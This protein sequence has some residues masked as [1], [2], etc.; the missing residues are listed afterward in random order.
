[1]PHTAP[2]IRLE[3]GMQPDFLEEIN[4]IPGGEHVKDCIQ[5]G[6]CSGSCPAA[7]NMRHTPRQI[8]AMIRAGMR[9]E[10]LTSN[11]M[12]MCA[13]CYLCQSRCP[14]NIKITDIMYALKRVALAEGKAQPKAS[15]MAQVFVDNINAYGRNDERM[16]IFNYYLK[17]NPGKFLSYAP[18]GLS[19]VNKGLLSLGAPER[20]KNIDQIRKIVA[21]VNKEG[22]A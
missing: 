19:M 11:A 5:C 16:L 2:V 20:I 15:Y 21:Y 14:S 17:T 3:R 7:P 6:T 18:I 13:S 10:V 22:T 8:I 9:D 1:M 4:E 12:W